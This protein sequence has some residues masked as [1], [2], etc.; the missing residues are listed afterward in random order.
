MDASPDTNADQIAHWNGAGAGAW[1]EAQSTMDA[2]FAGLV[3]LLTE[4]ILAGFSG[5]VLDVGCGTGATSLAAA[6]KLD[7]T[8]HC[9]GLDVSTPMVEM[10]RARAAEVGLPASFVVGDAQIHPF[11]PDTFDHIVSR[12]GVMFFEDPVAAFANLRS[13]AK[14]GAALRF[15]A[16]RSPSENAFMTTATRAAKPYLPEQPAHDPDAPGQFAF[17][18]GDKVRRILTDAGWR[19]IEGRP[20][21]VECR[22]PAAD[23]DLFLTR[24]GP[25][26][27]YLGDMNE[28]TR[29]KVIETVR[30][31]FE[32]FVHGDE[33]RYTAAC[34]LV[35]ARS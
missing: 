21:D 29:A 10:A 25:L 33:I 3:P 6:R 32:P 28:D 2:M 4:T 31:A 23:L 34:W 24:L 13:G 16:W 26:G 18:D 5:Q 20:I 27:R 30:A 1:I 11:E 35:E 7:G 9:L 12:F 22:F 8:G 17:A 15:A 19:D 14:A